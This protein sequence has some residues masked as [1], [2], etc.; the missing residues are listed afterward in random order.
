MS[1]PRFFPSF[2]IYLF[3]VL[4][5]SYH[6]RIHIRCCT[7]L[8]SDSAGE[9]NLSL[10]H[11]LGL[12]GFT[13][14]SGFQLWRQSMFWLYCYTSYPQHIWF[15]G[16]PT[17]RLSISRL[18]NLEASSEKAIVSYICLFTSH[19]IINYASSDIEV[20]PIFYPTGKLKDSSRKAS[21]KKSNSKYK[22]S[23]GFERG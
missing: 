19:L 20:C 18:T 16:L 14:A 10:V 8:T 3:F 23:L 4:R 1:R 11:L 7:S 22:S 12:N 6:S 21:R 2:F 5:F 15:Q 9:F 13:S 17:L